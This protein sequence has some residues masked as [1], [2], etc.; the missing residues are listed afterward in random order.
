[1]R[2]TYESTQSIRNK[3]KFSYLYWIPLKYTRLEPMTL[4]SASLIFDDR[5]VLQQ[6]P[7]NR[8]GGECRDE[9]KSTTA[10]RA[11]TPYKQL[12]KQ[13]STVKSPIKTMRLTEKT[14]ARQCKGL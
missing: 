13:R 6:L 4:G 3:V 1:M 8:S 10:T 2:N 9:H 11:G 7:G 5:K 14:Y 12:L